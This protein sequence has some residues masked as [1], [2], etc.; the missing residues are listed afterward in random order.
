VI[1]DLDTKESLRKRDL[2]LSVAS[3]VM[4]STLNNEVPCR[5]CSQNLISFL[6]K[7]RG[8]IV[9]LSMNCTKQH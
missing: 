4:H 9:Y 6:K 3:H 7:I 1:K 8:I 5:N 2:L